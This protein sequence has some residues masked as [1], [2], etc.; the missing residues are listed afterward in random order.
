MTPK[1]ELL[2]TERFK[3]YLKTKTTKDI[4]WFFDSYLTNCQQIDYKI[5]D[6]KTTKDSIYFTVKNKKSGQRPISLFMLK[7]GKVISNNGLQELELKKQ[8]VVPKLQADKLVLNYDKKVPE[9]DLR[10]NW[11]SISGNSLFNKP[12]QFD[13]LKM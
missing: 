1:K 9:F 4:D 5:T 2:T 11:K 6:V 3:T 7:D 13:S 8:F 12:F 10:N